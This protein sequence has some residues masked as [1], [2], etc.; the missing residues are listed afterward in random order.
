MLA[1]GEAELVGFGLPY[2]ANPDLP[3]RYALAAPL[4][5]PDLDRLGA[6]GAAGYI[7][8]PTLAQQSAAATLA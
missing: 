2:L 6:G 8:Y 5:D 4:N 1:A 7:D 3:R